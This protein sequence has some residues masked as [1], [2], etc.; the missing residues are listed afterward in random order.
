M[1]QL[2]VDGNPSKK[3][4]HKLTVFFGVREMIFDTKEDGIEDIEYSAGTAGVEY[5]VSY[6]NGNVLQFRGNCSYM[7]EWK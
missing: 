2:Y 3:T 5:Q 1:S 6:T 7:A 4:I